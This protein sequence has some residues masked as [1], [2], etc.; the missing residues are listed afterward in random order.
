MLPRPA[1][2]LRMSITSPSSPPYSSMLT[3][4]KNTIWLKAMVIM[5]K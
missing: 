1:K 2:R 3:K 5:M 4:A